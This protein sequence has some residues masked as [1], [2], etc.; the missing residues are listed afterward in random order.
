M[1]II[2]T[3]IGSHLGVVGS[4]QAIPVAPVQHLRSGYFTKNFNRIEDYISMRNSSASHLAKWK[5]KLGSAEQMIPLVG[6][7]YRDNSVTIRI[8]GKDSTNLLRIEF[9]CLFS[10]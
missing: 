6:Q 2:G 3:E 1:A 7:F 8:F 4:G 5:E 10:L 9:V